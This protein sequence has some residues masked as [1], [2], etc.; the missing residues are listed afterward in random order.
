MQIQND[1]KLVKRNW[2]Y[3]LQFTENEQTT[4]KLLHLEKGSHISY[5]YH[6]FRVEQWF[7]IKG[8]AVVTR[9][10][11]KQIMLPGQTVT[12]EKLEKHMIEGL[13]NCVILEVS[14]GYFDEQD[15]V[16]L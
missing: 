2:G 10:I 12:I 16:R 1:V 3:F 11:E 13:E 8:K 15:I 9:G 4:V 6:N 5:Q 14:K 7:L